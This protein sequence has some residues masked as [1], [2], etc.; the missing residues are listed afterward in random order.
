MECIFCGIVTGEVPA[1]I[2]YQDEEF[3]AFS[4]VAPQAPKHLVII[5]KS[6]I[7][8]VADLGVEHQGL[9]G[10]LIL[11][12]RE[13]ARREGVADSGYRLAMNCGADAGQVV[14]HLHLHLIGGRRLSGRLG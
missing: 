13:L 8:S 14:P 12:A 6:H 3:I 9:A 11:L 1:E 10:R 4:D 2:V 7:P 5:P